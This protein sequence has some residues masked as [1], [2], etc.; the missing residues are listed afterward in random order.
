MITEHLRQGLTEAA[1]R[2]FGEGPWPPVTVFRERDALRADFATNWP[3]RLARPLGQSPDSI[4]RALVAAWPADPALA[5]AVPQAGY[6]NVR[7]A[8]TW[9]AERLADKLEAGAAR[10]S[11]PTAESPFAASSSLKEA[12][13]PADDHGGPESL[14]DP[15]TLVAYTRARLASLVR[16][17]ETEGLPTWRRGGDL[18]LADPLTR[19]VV[20]R[21]LDGEPSERNASDLCR[22]FHRFYAARR[23]F[24]QPDVVASGRLAVIRGTLLALEPVMVLVTDTDEPN[25]RFESR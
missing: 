17:A 10:L 16:L 19:E 7:L 22:A 9:L 13:E 18:D 6:V 5:L 8:D 3:M 12:S 4:A 15:R 2:A 11:A 1:R 24:G 14:D 25:R 23:V 21:L 20:L